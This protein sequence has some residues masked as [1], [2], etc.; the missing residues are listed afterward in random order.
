[1]STA[2]K[3]RIL[4][5][6]LALAIAFYFVTQRLAGGPPAS[7][8]AAGSTLLLELGGHYVEAPAASPLARLAG[9]ETRPFIGLLAMFSLAERDDRLET[10]VLRI[11][12]LDI[13]WGKA[14]EL[15][16][17][18]GRLRA[19]GRHTIAWL[20][21]QSFQASKELYVATAADE[22]Y[23]TPGAGLPLVGLAAE[24]VFLG[25]FWEKLGIDFDVAKAGRYKSAV[26]VYTENERTVWHL[27]KGRPWFS[28]DGRAGRSRGPKR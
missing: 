23:V 7:R 20:E 9:D 3:I 1:M 2:S 16:D 6:L 5:L 8:V 15:R 4:L 11:R 12:P 26:E 28:A 25:G 14:D 17:A 22:V 18:I 13:G 24:Y 19:K 10:V 27:R 21:I